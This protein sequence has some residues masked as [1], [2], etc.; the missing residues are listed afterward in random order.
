MTTPTLFVPK[1]APK[2]EGA[3][4]AELQG[5]VS[6][7]IARY[8]LTTL[9]PLKPG[10]TVHDNGC[11]YGAATG[12]IMATNPPADIKITATDVNESWLG[13]LKTKAEKESWPVKAEV[14][15]ACNI[16]LSDSSFDFSITDFV[17]M[18]LKE[19]V[20]AAKHIKRTLKPGGTAAVAI[21]E[22][23]TWRDAMLHAHHKTR[24]ADAPCP[25][26]MKHDLKGAEI[27][28]IL[29]EAGWEDVRYEEKAAWVTTKDLKRWVML[30]WS[31]LATPVGGWTQDDEEKWD[32]AVEEVIRSLKDMEGYEEINGE[33]RVKMVACVAIYTKES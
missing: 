12:E 21:W 30:A 25:P 5:H 13:Q 16:T 22:S 6:E 4:L 11:G 9:P 27:K 1:Q 26:F 18:G 29:N 20:Q 14:M 32:E 33:H 10:S 24:G 17:F 7:D 15:D 19:P 3:L 23:I 28:V 8:I 2:F 31:F